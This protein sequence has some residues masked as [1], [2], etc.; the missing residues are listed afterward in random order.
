MFDHRPAP[1]PPH[2]WTSRLVKDVLLET[3][4]W[5]HFTA[6]QV[7]PRG[8]ARVAQL[9]W[10]PTLEDHL[11]EGWGLPE[12][13]DETEVEDRAIPTFSQAQIKLHSQAMLWQ[14]RY[15]YPDNVGSSRMLA[16]WLRTKV[17][18]GAFDR[19]VEKMG[20]SRGH[21]YRLRDR[22]LGL[23]AA[24]LTADRVSVP[25]PVSL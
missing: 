5:A 3:M 16:L 9:Q 11:K 6:G 23:I 12:K 18:R 10:S 8:F 22:A 25:A 17:R 7:G 21:A 24:G 1:L 19:A 14:A 15:L 13:T 2:T 4:T 20:V